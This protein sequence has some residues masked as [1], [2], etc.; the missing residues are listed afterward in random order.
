[1]NWAVLPCIDNWIFDVNRGKVLVSL[2]NY[3]D[4]TPGAMWPSPGGRMQFGETSTGGI[5]RLFNDELG[6]KVSLANSEMVAIGYGVYWYNGRRQT[7]NYTY[8]HR[9]KLPD[10]F[11][12]PDK[13]HFL[14]YSWVGPEDL[15]GLRESTATVYPY[16]VQMIEAVFSGIPKTSGTLY[17]NEETGVNVP[18]NRKLSNV[19]E[20]QKDLRVRLVGRTTEKPDVAFQRYIDSHIPRAMLEAIVLRPGGGRP[21]MLCRNTPRGDAVPV[22]IYERQPYDETPE[23][24][25]LRLAFEKTGIEFTS[26]FTIGVKNEINKRPDGTVLTHDVTQVRTITPAT[27]KLADPLYVWI[28]LESAMPYLEKE[29]PRLAQI[30]EQNGLLKGAAHGPTKITDFVSTLDKQAPRRLMDLSRRAA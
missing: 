16:V 14:G 22:V 4:S 7:P 2:R 12:V 30:L 11:R 13:H 24:A 8:V 29:E 21:Q 23:A 1:M 26:P 28:D 17:H 6:M 27:S 5:T 20:A 25:T 18:E 9:M 10:N 15:P 3:Q 19:G